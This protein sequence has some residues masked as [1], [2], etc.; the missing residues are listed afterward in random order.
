VIEVRVGTDIRDNRNGPGNRSRAGTK[1]GSDS[2][3]EAPRKP[4]GSTGSRPAAPA[5]DALGKGETAIYDNSAP[6]GREIVRPTIEPPPDAE[7]DVSPTVRGVRPSAEPEEPEDSD[8]EPQDHRTVALDP[9][10]AQPRRGQTRSRTSPPKPGPKV[11]TPPPLPPKNEPEAKNIHDEEEEETASGGAAPPLPQHATVAGDRYVIEALIG[12]GPESRVY[13]ALDRRENRRCAIKEFS[14][15]SRNT[16]DALVASLEDYEG[17]VPGAISHKN[18]IE[19]FALARD[20]SRGPLV[21]MEY[22]AGGTLENV[23]QRKNRLLAPDEA[24][25]VYAPIVEAVAAANGQ[26]LFVGDVHPRQIFPGAGTSEPKLDATA[27]LLGHSNDELSVWLERRHRDD[28][29]PELCAQEPEVGSASEVY[30]IGAA[31]SN[32]VLGKSASEARKSMRAAPKELRQ[33]L[34][35]C[36]A[37]DPADRH[38]SVAH[39]ARALGEL[40]A[41]SPFATRIFASPVIL[42]GAI[43]VVAVAGILFAGFQ[44][45]KGP[46]QTILPAPQAECPEKTELDSTRALAPREGELAALKQYRALHARFP[47][48]NEVSAQIAQLVET[49]TIKGFKKE[50]RRKLRQVPDTQGELTEEQRREIAQSVG[51]VRAIDPNDDLVGYWSEKLRRAE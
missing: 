7:T 42:I 29:A 18:V 40:G 23:I 37:D 44:I 15:E 36:L 31:L 38:P 30:A 14:G 46:E 8:N 21:I 4:S 3:A 26:N 11:S 1:K 41:A 25:R 28:L 5:I 24:A 32:A 48:C 9:V 50:H 51:I 39:V 13:R 49:D 19:I 2:N 33:M 20:R 45:T 35:K 16:M 43:A 47:A 22:V 6:P 10:W 34:E 17:P 27:A 12:E